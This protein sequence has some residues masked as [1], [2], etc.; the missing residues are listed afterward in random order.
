MKTSKILALILSALLFAAPVLAA[1]PAESKPTAV[2]TAASAAPGKINYT[3]AFLGLALEKAKLYSGKAEDAIGKGVDI[4][5]E[6]AKPTAVEFLRWRAWSHGIKTLF[7]PLFLGMF[8]ALQLWQWPRFEFSYN[9][10]LIK[11][12][13]LNV[14]ASV[15][16]WVGIATC[17]IGTLVF[18]IPNFMSLIQLWVAPRIYVIEQ[19][20]ELMKK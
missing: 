4:A 5:M 11:G 14:V 13:E 19:V 2:E 17:S 16:A 10:R 7:P 15:V 9:E 6:E 3:D 1:E 8:I 20:I 12:T 18:S